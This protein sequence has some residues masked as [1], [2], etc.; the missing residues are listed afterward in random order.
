MVARDLEG[1]ASAAS[2][3]VPSSVSIE[4]PASLKASEETAGSKRNGSWSWRERWKAVTA[5]ISVR[6][7]GIVR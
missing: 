1:Q 5:R 6:F 7:P 3:N 4:I 2:Q